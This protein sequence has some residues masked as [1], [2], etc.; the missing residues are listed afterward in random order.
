MDIGKE[1]EELVV[2]PE[3]KPE[4]QPV[5]TPEPEKVTVS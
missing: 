1:E 5:K 2:V 4:K 3:I